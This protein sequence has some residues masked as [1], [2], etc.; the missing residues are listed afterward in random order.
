MLTLGLSLAG[1]KV[2][3]LRTGGPL[4]EVIEPIIN[5]NNLKVEGWF[6]NDR[7]HKRRSILLSSEIRDILPQ[8]F[9]VNDQEALSDPDDLVRLKEILKTHFELIGKHV[10]TTRKVRLGKVTDFA[11]EKD[12]AYIQKLYVMPSGLK[13]LAGG[14][15]IIDRSQIVEI[16]SRHIVVKETSTPITQDL[17][18]QQPAIAPAQP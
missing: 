12:Q 16:T 15:N 17:Q 4:G 14:G 5:P 18:T 13:S 2:L 8:G 9:V 11:V 6:V 3:S 1:K 7:F 10:M